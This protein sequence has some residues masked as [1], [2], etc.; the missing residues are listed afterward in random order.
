ME[1]LKSLSGEKYLSDFFLVGGTSL[2]LQ[3]GHRRSI[4]LDFFSHKNFESE[5]LFE[6]IKSGARGYLLKRISAGEL[7]GMLRAA[8]RN[9][10]AISPA[11]G[12]RLLDEFQ[13]LS[14][15]H[16]DAA[17]SADIVLTRREHEVLCLIAQSLSDQEIAEQLVISVHT[18]KSHVHNILAK[19]QLSHRYEAARFAL[20]QGLIPQPD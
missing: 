5:Q 1:L 14:R 10:A 3:I 13:R 16:T 2:A 7:V 15:L 8:L 17:P 18:V 4:D 11:L 20:D 19:L 12:G 9:E 6:A